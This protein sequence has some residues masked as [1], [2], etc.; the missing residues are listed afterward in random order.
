MF[1]A[2]IVIVYNEM[3]SLYENEYN[4][5]SIV[6]AYNN[7]CMDNVVQSIPLLSDLLYTD[8][9]YYKKF[10]N[11]SISADKGKQVKSVI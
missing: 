9:E 2:S 4:I 8:V 5:D 1:L 11:R 3:S 10:F 6:K 7:K